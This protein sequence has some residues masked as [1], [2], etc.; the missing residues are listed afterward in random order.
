MSRPVFKMAFRL[1]LPITGSAAVGLVMVL[2]VVGALFPAVGDSI[3]K[4]DLPQGVSELLG[5][6]DYGTVTGWYRG[7]IASVYGPLVFAAVAI[8]GAA[9]V[10][11][12]EEEDRILALVLSYPV[13]RS[14]LVAAK[15]AAIAAGVSILA[16]ATW[17]G[18]IAGVAV[19]GGGIGAGRLAALSLHL[20]FYGMASGAVALALGAGTG[21]RT[22]AAGGAAAFAV[23]GYLVNGFAPL[24]D[25]IAWLKYLSPFYFYA[26]HDPLANGVHV[27]D[28][29]VL[30]LFALALTGVAMARLGRRD[31]R[32]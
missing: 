19:A 21:R 28:L 1:R 23:F 14:S 12:G 30:G 5:G 25:A 7:E 18:L 15:G 22:L 2:I 4:L 29:V 11:A 8:T 32:G 3:G 26:A 31:L 17:G 9:G 6:A 20:A 27:G 24:V 10:T 16:V 13:R